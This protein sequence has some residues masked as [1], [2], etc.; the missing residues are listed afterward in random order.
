M[1][2]YV[3]P[4]KDML[5]AMNELADFGEVVKLPGCEEL[6]PDLAETILDEAG[7]FAGEVL[8]PLNT[9][10]DRE[11]A[12][13]KDGS[14]T[15]SPGF[16]QAYRQFVENGWATLP[17]S[18]EFGGQGMPYGLAVAVNEMWK[19][20]NLAFSLCPMLTQ[21]AIEALLHHGS[22]EIKQ[23]YLPKM[24]SGEWTG[25]MN[26][27]EPQAG[28]DLAAVRTRAVPEGDHYRI[29]GTKIFITWGEHDYT[30]NIIHTVLA[31]LPD[32]PEGVKGIS[33][34]VVPKYLVNGDGSLGARN[35]LQCVSLEHKLG[36]HGSPTAVMSYGEKGGAIG[37]L[38]GEPNRGLEYMFTMMNH[39]RLAVG[40]EGVAIAERAYQ[41]ALAYARERVQGRPLGSKD[42]GATIIEH[43]DVRRMLMTM[44]AQTEAMRALAYF[45]ASCMDRAA[46][47]PDAAQRQH[48]QA[49][50]DLLTPVSK[51]WQ[52]EIGIE[53]ATNG[54]QVHG[55]M[56]FIEETGAAQFL[57][58]ARITTIYEGTTGI[59]ALD[60]V[61]R[62]V[63]RD[64]GAAMK[65]LLASMQ[66]TLAEATAVGGEDLTAI[67]AAFKEALAHAESTSAYVAGTFAGDPRAVAAGSTPYLMLIGTLCGGWQ[68]LR[69]ALVA[70]RR[71]KADAGDEFAGAKLATAR[72]Y[73]DHLLPRCQAYARE[74][75]H[76]A[77]STLRLAAAQF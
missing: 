11:G 37:Y 12:K 35:D 67:A 47:H 30:D 31:R 18:T 32:A 44:K 10:G 63:A 77:Q 58:D 50:V 66:A 71:L 36:I 55:G 2:A 51:G 74:I 13:L 49:L 52:T 53:V 70:H 9:A 24:V 17:A 1:S 56:G 76:G 29:T 46:R 65:Q 62:K 25:T 43:P 5:F 72:F 38:V 75:M 61:G 7:K 42:A 16:K 54:I 6:S 57:R 60:L 34:F 33:L 48:Y 8:A 69:A 45:A 68:M 59:Q 15:T 64:G 22:G 23:R 14:V 19:S 27:T 39:A 20:S 3:A 40:L 73:A 28:S 21:G 4:V 41:K 26:L